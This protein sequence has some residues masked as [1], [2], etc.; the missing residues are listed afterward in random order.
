MSVIAFSD[1]VALMER[2]A[3]KIE[4]IYFDLSSNIARRPSLL[5][6]NISALAQKHSLRLVP[7][8]HMWHSRI[9]RR[10]IQ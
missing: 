8:E 3:A 1:D 10:L 7:M 6:N 2:E 4:D 9:D 5:R